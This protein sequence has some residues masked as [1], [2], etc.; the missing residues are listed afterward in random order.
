MLPTG[1]LDSAVIATAR[2][3]SA[4]KPEELRAKKDRGH[5]TSVKLQV[6]EDIIND[7][8]LRLVHEDDWSDYGMRYKATSLGETYG[9]EMAGRI[10]EYTH[11]ERNQVN[12]CARVDDITFAVAINGSGI[13]ASLKVGDSRVG[14][15][16]ILECRV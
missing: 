6:C 3:S 9:Y 4:M 8:K 13:L 10:K 5:P 11:N 1:F 12:H 14:R 7:L 15:S 16:N 2:S